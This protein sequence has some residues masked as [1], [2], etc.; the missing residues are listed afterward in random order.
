MTDTP[1]SAPAASGPPASAGDFE[2]LRRILEDARWAPSGDNVQ[3][4]HFRI[5]DTERVEVDLHGDDSFYERLWNAKGIYLAAGGL[6]ET[7]CIVASQLGYRMQWK[8]KPDAGD[9]TLQLRFTTDPSVQAD[10]LHQVVS[11]RSVRRHAYRFKP[12]T[13]QQR[14]RLQQSVGNGF[15]LVCKESAASRWHAARLN[16]K[17]ADIRLRLRETFDVSQK[18]LD[19]ERD[20]SPDRIP[21]KAIAVDA[22]TRQL[23]KFLLKK[24]SRIDFMNRYAGGTV[25][26]AM[27]M[28]LVPGVSCAAHFL[29]CFPAHVPDTGSPQALMHAGQA[30]QRLWLQATAEGL[31]LQPSM[32][33]ML[34]AGYH[35]QPHAVP[36]LAQASRRMVDWIRD[37]AQV[38]PHRIAFMGRIGTP[39]TPHVNA[40]SVRKPLSDLLHESRA[41]KST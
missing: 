16:M 9:K 17:A 26:P 30:M 2:P 31:A 27:Q 25:L 19:W 11:T 41:P 14:A 13:L 37:Y 28:D 8:L 22:M 1:F 35:L 20:F 10:S 24:W 12:L 3:P 4:W 18:I 38:E 7:L 6:L 23:M 36:R 34:M 21:V 33:P 40:R 29:I 15:E 32:A 39:R 5:M